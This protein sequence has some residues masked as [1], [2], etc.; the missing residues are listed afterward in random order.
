MRPGKLS[1]ISGIDPNI[2][3]LLAYIWTMLEESLSSEGNGHGARSRLSER[4]RVWRLVR[5]EKA[6]GGTEVK[7]LESK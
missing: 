7:L 4:E 6:P 5:P 3:A 2:L 1:K